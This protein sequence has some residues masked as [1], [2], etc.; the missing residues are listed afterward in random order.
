MHAEAVLS[1][2]H[3]WNNGSERDWAS[4]GNWPTFVRL[5]KGVDITYINERI[6]PIVGNYLATTNAFQSG[7]VKRAEVSLTPLKGYH[8]KNNEVKIMIVIVFILGLALLLT[9]TFNYSLISISSLSHRAKAI[10]VHKCN[11]AETSNIFGMFLLET[12]FVTGISTFAALFL[13]LNFRE[14]IVEL[15]GI[16]IETMFY[17]NNLWAP[18]IFRDNLPHWFCFSHICAASVHP[19]QGYGI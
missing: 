1:L 11:G 7:S 15:T 4:G 14:Q 8:L 6:N 13:I 2:N 3:P 16:P 17:L 9:A 19:H 10:S 5:K 18:A 12:L